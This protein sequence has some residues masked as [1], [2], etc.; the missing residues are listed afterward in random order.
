MWP[1]FGSILAKFGHQFASRWIWPKLVGF[2][3][4]YGQ[5]WPTSVRIGRCW[6]SFVRSQPS[7]ANIWPT[8]TTCGQ[9]WP[10]LDR[11]WP[12]SANFVSPASQLAQASATT[13]RHEW[14]A[15]PH[16]ASAGMPPS[17]EP[18]GPPQQYCKTAFSSASGQEARVT[19][20]RLWS[21]SAPRCPTE[22]SG[23]R[24]RSPNRG[25]SAMLPKA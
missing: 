20:F 16:P 12:N 17:Q 22:A 10:N 5:E 18:S 23:E 8:P 7:S 24:A 14:R 25:S 21:W 6:P 3:P 1:N 9:P 11:C 2:G 4:N 15:L 13:C 19:I